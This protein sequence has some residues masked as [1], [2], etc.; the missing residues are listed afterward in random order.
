MRAQGFNSTFYG[1]M[2]KICHLIQPFY[3]GVPIVQTLNLDRLVIEGTQHTNTFVTYPVCSLIQFA[4]ITGTYQTNAD[5]YKHRSNRDQLLQ[6]NLSSNHGR[7]HPIVKQLFYDGGIRMPLIIR[8]L[9]EIKANTTVDIWLVYQPGSDDP[10][11]YGI[12]GARLYTGF[13]P[14]WENWYFGA[15]TVDSIPPLLL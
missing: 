6:Q 5:A 12:R 1:S 11:D 3:Y 2:V 13:K 7:A 4:I 15:T 14:P 8:C 9:G 10:I